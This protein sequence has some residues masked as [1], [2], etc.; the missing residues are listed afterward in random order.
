MKKPGNL[1]KS[2]APVAPATTSTAMKQSAAK[3]AF[4]SVVEQGTAW[5]SWIDEAVK[6]EAVLKSK[7]PWSYLEAEEISFLQKRL[8]T[9]SPP[10]QMMVN[11]F[12]ITMVAGFEEYLRCVIREMVNSV[13]QSKLSF[14]K[15]D[16]I[17]RRANIRETAKLLR[18][19]DSPPDYLK[20]DEFE[21]CRQ[22][23]TCVP[24][25][26]AVELNANAF[27]DVEG[28]LKLVVFMERLKLL[29]KT[30]DWDYFGGQDNIKKAMRM[31]SVNTRSVAD[32]LSNEL[33]MMSRF[34]NRIAHTGGHA[35]DVT[36]QVASDHREILLVLAT[37]I[38][39]LVSV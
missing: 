4:E 24:G 2:A 30:V 16:V 5:V 38:D 23:G 25:S 15:L 28:L 1:G 7:I 17:L 10:L 18:R 8:K 37:T 21:L 13:S 36:P 3:V 9:N 14:D 33:I 20:L 22:I 11:S 27:A 19:M 34:R 12:Y 31:E 35:A 32:A 29:G 6:F 39:N 26:V